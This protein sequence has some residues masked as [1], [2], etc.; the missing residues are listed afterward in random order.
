M[1]ESGDNNYFVALRSQHNAGDTFLLHGLKGDFLKHIRTNDS[2]ENTHTLRLGGALPR[3]DIVANNSVRMLI[4]QNG[5]TTFYGKISATSKAFLIDHPTKK[6]KKLQ[7]GSLEGPENGVYVR[8]KCESNVIE[9]PDYWTGLVDED[10]ITVQLTPIGGWQKL[11]VKKIEDNKVY[12]GKF[13][14]GSP[15]FFYNVYGERKD[16]EKMEVE[17]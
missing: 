7:H 1:R 8:G 5:S 15:K 6:G 2:D 17:Y 4:D 10:T 14:F 11:Y 13:G 3:V 16:I 12:V 9:L